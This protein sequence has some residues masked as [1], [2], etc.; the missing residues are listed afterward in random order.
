MANAL[1]NSAAL[2]AGITDPD[3]RANL[4]GNFIYPVARLLI[5]NDLADKLILPKSGML[6]MRAWATTGP[7]H[8]HAEKFSNW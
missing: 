3:R 5:G 2:I 8:A 7:T 6:K 1:I 4:V